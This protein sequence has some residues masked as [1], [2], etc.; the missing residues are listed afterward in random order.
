MTIAL[1]DL[2]D[3]ITTYLDKEV[4]VDITKVTTNVEKHEEGSFTLTVTNAAAPNGVKLIGLALHMTIDD[5]TVMDILGFDDPAGIH[6]S[7][8]NAGPKSPVV[9]NGDVAP[10]GEMCVFFNGDAGVL[11]V[12][13]KATVEIQYRGENAGTTTL[14]VHPHATVS[15][16]TLFPPNQAGVNSKHDITILT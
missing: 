15:T 2:A 3:A 6:T 5:P 11:D 12:G 9:V 13:D 7:R 4:T 14:K 1:T 16:D 8:Q 10:N